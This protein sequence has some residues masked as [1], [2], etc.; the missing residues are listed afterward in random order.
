VVTG[1]N[2]KL[3]YFKKGLIDEPFFYGKKASLPSPENIGINSGGLLV[4][5][6]SCLF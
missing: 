5:D 2:S 6:N 4:S 3:I 1:G